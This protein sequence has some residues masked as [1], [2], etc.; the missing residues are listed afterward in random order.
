MYLSDYQI[1]FCNIYM[2][3]KYSKKDIQMK[4]SVW[5]RMKLKKSKK[6]Y[7]TTIHCDASGV[8]HLTKGTLIDNQS[9]QSMHVVRC[10]DTSL[11][12][13]PS[14]VHPSLLQDVHTM[15]GSAQQRKA[16]F[17]ATITGKNYEG[18]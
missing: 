9:A 18:H 12:L 11:S 8:K 2:C 10:K 1:K 6:W 13:T 5:M 7:H 17:V 3:Q 14:F 4:G 16:S 15:H